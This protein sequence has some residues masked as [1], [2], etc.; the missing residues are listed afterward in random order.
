MAQG[1]GRWR[2]WRGAVVG[3]AFQLFAPTHMGCFL[4]Y[5]L[6]ENAITQVTK[7][8][9]K[10]RRQWLFVDT[11]TKNHLL[12][13]PEAPPTKWARWGSKSLESPRAAP[14]RDSMKELRDAGL[15]GTMVALDFTKRRIAP[16]QRH[17]ERM[18]SYNGGEDTMRLSHHRLTG[19]ELANAMKTLF[20][21]EVS[22][23]PGDIVV[24]PL[25]NCDE[26][27]MLDV[28]GKIPRLTLLYAHV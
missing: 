28:R 25:F 22:L 10:F 6:G 20:T 7:K 18:W 27:V 4:L 1:R 15:T 9:D 12:D 26:A 11:Q 19:N 8:V 21:T 5:H 17:T 14:V 23:N 16:L 3:D 13:I 2:K 24:Q